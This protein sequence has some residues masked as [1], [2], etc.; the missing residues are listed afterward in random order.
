MPSQLG[1]VEDISAAHGGKKKDKEKESLETP[2]DASSLIYLMERINGPGVY[3]ILL[4]S[5]LSWSMIFRERDDRDDDSK[6][7]DGLFLKKP[8]RV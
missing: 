5:L 2:H 6:E 7:T 3:K 4:K 8:S 1:E